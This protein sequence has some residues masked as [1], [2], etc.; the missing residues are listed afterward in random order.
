MKGDRAM[1]GY[2]ATEIKDAVKEHYAQRAKGASGCCDTTDTTASQL[3][4]E[5][6][7][8]GLPDGALA[9][10]A[11]CGNPTAL[12]GLKEGEAVLDLGSG[13]GIDCFLAARAVG[14]KGRVIGVDMTPDMVEL[15]R[16]NARILRANNVEFHLAEME[17]VPLPDSSVNVVISNCVVNLSPDKDAVFREAFRVLT[18]GGRL[19][20]SDIVLHAPWPEGAQ[21]DLENW[22]SCIGGAEPR[23]TY[24]A[25]LRKAGFTDIAL[26]QEAG[27]SYQA[28]DPLRQNAFSAR[29]VARKPA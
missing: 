10:A 12:A 14:P 27:R 11:G 17:N 26:E 4:V 5:E 15:A 23:D 3:Y 29:V 25:R 13:G 22:A 2:R 21:P 24:L 16:R 28:G 6:Q 7:L 18:P 19:H 20:V 8:K 9:A 1:T